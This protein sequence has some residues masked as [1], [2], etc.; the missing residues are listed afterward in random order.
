MGV[1]SRM[2]CAR[3]LSYLP[4]RSFSESERLQPT[5]STKSAKSWRGR[6]RDAISET[7]RLER[8]SGAA[9]LRGESWTEKGSREGSTCIHF[10]VDL[11]VGT[12]MG[13]D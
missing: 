7:E 12:K 9:R 3:G 11:E 4:E 13:S 10:W 1:K 2:E 6:V 5:A 8:A